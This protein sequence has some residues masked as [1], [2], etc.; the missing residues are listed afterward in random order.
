MKSGIQSVLF[1][2]LSILVLSLSTSFGALNGVKIQAEVPEFNGVTGR[3]KIVDENFFNNKRALIYF[4]YT[5]CGGI[6]Y[7]RVQLFKEINNKLKEDVVFVFV[8]I[9]PDNDTKKRLYSY[10]D[11]AGDNFHSLIIKDKSFFDSL[12]RQLANGP[13]LRKDPV[14]HSDFV[15]FSDDGKLKSIYMGNLVDSEKI[16]EDINL[17]KVS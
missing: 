10:F 8:T 12:R 4:G 5:A 6:C 15:Y 14:N 11:Y 3:G 2:A 7:P 1:I 16:I 17:L 9:D 13:D